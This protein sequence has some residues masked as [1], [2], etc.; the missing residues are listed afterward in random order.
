MNYIQNAKLLLYSSIIR[1]VSKIKARIMELLKQKQ[2]LYDQ[3]TKLA[4]ESNSSRELAVITCKIDEVN[5]DLVRLEKAYGG[6]TSFMSF[7]VNYS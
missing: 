4:S 2:N 6:D 7:V 1:G 3:L 5:K